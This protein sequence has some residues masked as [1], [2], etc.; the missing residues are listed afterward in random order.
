MT[1]RNRPEHLLLKFNIYILLHEGRSFHSAWKVYKRIITA[2]SQVGQCLTNILKLIIA[3]KHITKY[4]I[5]LKRIE[6]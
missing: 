6:R 5:I 1:K 3:K 4:K 2:N